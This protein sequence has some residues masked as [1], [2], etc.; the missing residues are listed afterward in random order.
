MVADGE[1]VTVEV[2]D[3]STVSSIS[4]SLYDAG[5]IARMSDFEAAVNAQNAGASLKSGVYMFTG[6]M[7]PEEIVNALVAGPSST[8]A[9]LSIPEGATLD[10]IAGLVEQAYGGSISADDFKQAASSAEPYV[11]DYPF[12]SE[13]GK[14]LF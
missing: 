10:T 12:L 8:Q 1:Q 11:E 6:G 14:R 3:G 4:Q 7:T 5:L 13:A 9:G 2:A